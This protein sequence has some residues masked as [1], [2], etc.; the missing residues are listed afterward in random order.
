MFKLTYQ[1]CKF[2]YWCGIIFS[3]H[4]SRKR[5]YTRQLQGW[6]KKGFLVHKLEY[7]T[8]SHGLKSSNNT[9]VKTFKPPTFH[10]PSNAISRKHTIE[11][12]KSVFRCKWK[13]IIQILLIIVK[14]PWKININTHIDTCMFNTKNHTTVFY[15]FFWYYLTL[16]NG[17]QSKQHKLIYLIFNGCKTSIVYFY[18]HSYEQVHY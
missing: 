7:K 6:K 17:H 10:S 16:S 15:S 3:Q 12:E 9:H 4:N 14:R 18:Y 11:I 2:R 8:L 1:K 13:M 5:C